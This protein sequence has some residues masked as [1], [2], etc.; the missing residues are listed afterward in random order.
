MI[1]QR[2]ARTAALAIAAAAALT[3][4]GAGAAQAAPAIPLT[5]GQEVPKPNNFGAHG[6]FSYE[7]D[8]AANEFCYTLDVTGLSAPATA[9]HVHVAPRNVAGPVVVPLGVPNETDFSVSGCTIVN[10]E[11]LLD[12]I[13]ANPRAYYVN[14]HN[15]NNQPGEIRGQLK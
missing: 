7:I 11:A 12:D 13:A 3:F 6:F 10:N 8:D 1:T 2:H 4:A 9:A 14:V 5:G 15:A